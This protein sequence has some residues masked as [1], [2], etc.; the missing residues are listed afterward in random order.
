MVK[1][2]YAE[3]MN[4]WQTSKSSPDVWIGRAKSEIG[5]AGGVVIAE[6]FGADSLTGRAAYMI[7]FHTAMDEEFKVMWPVLPTKKA[8]SVIAARIQAATMLYHDVKSRCVAARVFGLRTAF[9]AY[10]ILGDYGQTAAQMT[11]EQL[12]GS[13]PLL[14]A[15]GS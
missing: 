11:S 3:D 1:L 12:V 8:G 10:L 13:L 2:P 7:H 4:Y 6:G 5:K 9:F 14:L 15:S